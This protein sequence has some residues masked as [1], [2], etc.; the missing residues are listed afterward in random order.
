MLPIDCNLVLI[1]WIASKI[2]WWKR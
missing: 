2:V 1:A